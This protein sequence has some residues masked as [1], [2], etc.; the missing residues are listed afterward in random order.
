MTEFPG[1]P[2]RRAASGAPAACSRDAT[3]VSGQAAGSGQFPPIPVTTLTVLPGC[4]ISLNALRLA[5]ASGDP[6]AVVSIGEPVPGFA[7]IKKT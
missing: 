2:I 5:G 7:S 1:L 3:V 4:G 6:A